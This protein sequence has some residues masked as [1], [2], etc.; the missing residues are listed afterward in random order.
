MICSVFNIK[1]KENRSLFLIIFQLLFSIIFVALLDSK[2]YMPLSSPIQNTQ[3]QETNGFNW[4]KRL[5]ISWK[6]EMPKKWMETM[7]GCEIFLLLW[8][9]SL[10]RTEFC[11]GPL[12]PTIATFNQLLYCIMINEILFS[13]IK[14]KLKFGKLML[15][16]LGLVS[17][18]PF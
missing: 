2:N 10:N 15:K 9:V 4:K 11:Y 5:V 1:N 17:Q 7:F 13:N 16:I 18:I 3:N 14:I 12:D 6:N 8:I